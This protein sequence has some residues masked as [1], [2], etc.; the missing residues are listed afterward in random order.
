MSFLPESLPPFAA[1][2]IFVMG[3]VAGHQ[4]R[5]VWKSEGPRRQLWIY[6]TIASL[7]LLAVGLIP[8]DIQ[9]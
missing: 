9:P 4:Y 1:L 6:G 2:L 3:V 8:L 5:R 7:C